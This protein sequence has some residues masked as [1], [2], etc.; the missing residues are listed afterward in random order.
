M[1]RR[2]MRKPKADEESAM[3]YQKQRHCYTEMSKIF[4]IMLLVFR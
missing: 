4:K 3:F 1:R 2:L